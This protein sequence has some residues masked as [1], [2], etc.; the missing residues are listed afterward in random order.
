MNST[1]MLTYL[2]NI[3]NKNIHF[4]LISHL[5][6]FALLISLL[7]F[8]K[9]SGRILRH[10]QASAIGLL[11][12][13]VLIN[14]LHYG[15]PFHTIT[16]ALMLI[17][18]TIFQVT[19]KIENKSSAFFESPKKSVISIASFV[20]IFLGIWYPEFTKVNLV[21]SL[22]FSPLGIVPC[23]TM[24]AS[25]GFMNLKRNIFSRKSIWTLTIFAF[26]YGLIGTFVFKVYFDISLLILGILSVVVLSKKL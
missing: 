7:I 19:A 4:N 10:L 17:L 1:V 9:T 5:V 25:L 24:L 22:L 20:F 2:E 23:P 8:K 26:I 3:S 16:F 21:Q 11:L 12:S 18:C 13:F 14:A 15:N 6:I